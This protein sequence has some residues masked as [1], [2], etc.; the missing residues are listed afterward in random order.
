LAAL[1]LFLSICQHLKNKKVEEKRKKFFEKKLE[2]N[3][4]IS[5]KSN[6]SPIKTGV[7]LGKTVISASFRYQKRRFLGF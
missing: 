6:P 5:Q 3:K 7:N 1:F 2:K 4:K